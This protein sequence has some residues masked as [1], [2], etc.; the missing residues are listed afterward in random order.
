[1]SPVATFAD[2]GRGLERG[3]TFTES[4]QRGQPAL[5]HVIAHL[6]V[7]AFS[8]R[9]HDHSSAT[10]GLGR[11]GEGVSGLDPRRRI[12]VGARRCVEHEHGDVLRP[13]HDRREALRHPRPVTPHERVVVERVAH[14]DQLGDGRLDTPL[15]VM[16]ERFEAQR[17]MLGQVG[18]Q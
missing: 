6:L 18:H 12:V 15:L 14:R 4:E 10:G 2:A 7:E 11:I 5:Q 16:T 8:H 13:V 3:K 17:A 1:M 9:G